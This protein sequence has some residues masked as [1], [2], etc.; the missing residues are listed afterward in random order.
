[1]N[2]SLKL[3]F[4][5]LVL[6]RLHVLYGF[7]V[8]L[9]L[10]TVGSSVYLSFELLGRYTNS[11]DNNQ[12]WEDRSASYRILQAKAGLANAPANNVFASRNAPR[13][14]VNLDSAVTGFDRALQEAR[15]ELKRDVSPDTEAY[16]RLTS[17]LS[18]VERAMT[19]MVSDARIVLQTYSAGDL[20]TASSDMAEMDRQYAILNDSMQHLQAD[21]SLLQRNRFD[22][23][24]RGATKFRSV[25]HFI[26]FAVAVMVLGM[27]FYGYRLSRSVDESIAAQDQHLKAIAESETKFRL[28]NEQLEERVHRRTE[29]LEEANH[30]LIQSEIEASAARDAAEKANRAKSEFLANMSHEIRTPMNGVLGMLELALDTSLTADQRDYVET[31]HSS[32]ETL[33]DIINDI[34][35][36]SKIEAG[37][38]ELDETDFQLGESL[39]DTI[40]ALGLRADQKGLEFVIEVD[41]DVPDALVGDI[42]RLRQVIVNL[43]GN[44]IKFTEQGEVVLH[45]ATQSRN[46]DS[47]VL[48]F[49]V[50]DTGI[51]IESSQQAKVFEAFQQADSSTTRKY[52]GTGLGLA[53][54]AR[55]VTMMGGRITLSSEPGKGSVFEFAILFRR[56]VVGDRA[57]E[58]AQSP[59]LDGLTALVVDDNATNRRI[60]DGMLRGWGIVPTLA[61]SAEDALE[62]LSNGERTR[63][64]LILTDSRMPGLSGFELVERIRRDARKD[65]PTIL[66]LSSARRR[67]DATRSRELGIAAY[68]TKPIRRTALL[69][70]IRSAV[71]STF[72]E[73]RDTEPVAMSRRRTRSL[74]ILVAEDNA[75]NQK[76]AAGILEKAG[77]KFTVAENGEQA[78]AAAR[79]GGYDVILMDVQMPIMGGIEATQI[80]R[81]DEQRSGS[82]VPIIAV[83]A[84]AMKGDREACLAA[85]MDAYLPKPIQSAKLLSLIAELAGGAPI[86]DDVSD[87]IRG[88]SEAQPE[89][90]RDL[91]E[92]QLMSTVAGDG[93]LAGELAEIFL[94]EFAPRMKA[95]ERAIANED[96]EQL[97]LTAHALRGSAGS[98]S[99]ITVSERAG[100]LESMGRDA[101]LSAARA[102]FRQLKSDADRLKKRLK[103]LTRDR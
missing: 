44:A 42:G 55:I 12:E 29:E 31:A 34:L 10:L 2:R 94:K 91:D 19:A 37:R 26:A 6:P 1:M 45:V 35:D 57:G 63:F 47:A 98:I 90:D 102:E 61:E 16:T 77:H 69:A 56:Q 46:A 99:A 96:A 59:D 40:S 62:K 27:G 58:I 7:L 81:E 95:I 49:S 32:A 17:D 50:A 4:A 103:K 25:E 66:M 71:R 33:V 83:T 93:R 8:A 82:H 75:V 38:L 68:L 52:G 76:L 43:V 70:A 64:S 101:K 65:Y 85:G 79:T 54:S 18:S 23:E 72:E 89:L 22:E 30:A 92:K 11:V 3:P 67:Q 13:E 41:D 97:R 9:V 78:V 15:A 74:R 5:N 80:I 20:A 28:L 14:R 24:I 60:L 51:G 84:R 36:F 88:I 86:D 53:I 100:V 39:A 48:R 21:L 87:E 73:A